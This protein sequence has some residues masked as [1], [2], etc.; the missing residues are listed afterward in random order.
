MSSGRGA[1]IPVRGIG[2]GVIDPEMFR[3]VSS[4]RFV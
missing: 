1:A 4:M 2:L 3:Y